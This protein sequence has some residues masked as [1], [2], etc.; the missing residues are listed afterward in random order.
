M[1]Y[2]INSV[3]LISLYGDGPMQMHIGLFKNE[4]YP[5]VAV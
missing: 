4:V 1:Y 2:I 3:P 5:Q